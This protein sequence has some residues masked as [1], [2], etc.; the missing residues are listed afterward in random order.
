MTNQP[1]DHSYSTVPYYKIPCNAADYVPKDHSRCFYFLHTVNDHIAM[2][3]VT[4][5]QVL[6]LKAYLSDMPTISDGSLVID[7]VAGEG[8]GPRSRGITL[9]GGS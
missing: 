8:E 4:S 7:E 6:P 9:A 1:I 5:C 3:V 2:T